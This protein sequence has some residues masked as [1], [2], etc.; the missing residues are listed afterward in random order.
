ML[1]NCSVSVLFG[2]IVV[3]RVVWFT[4]CVVLVML[5]VMFILNVEFPGLSMVVFGSAFIVMLVRFVAFRFLVML[6]G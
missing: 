4:L 2:F 3:S 5:S 6:F 1:V